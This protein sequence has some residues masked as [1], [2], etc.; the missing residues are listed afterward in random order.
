MLPFLP[1][2]NTRV[3]ASTKGPAPSGSVLWPVASHSSWR[4]WG[5]IPAS[6][7]LHCCSLCL[8]HSPPGYYVAGSLTSWGLCAVYTA[9]RSSWGYLIWQLAPARCSP[10]WPHSQ[11]NFLQNTPVLQSSAFHVCASPA[12]KTQLLLSHSVVSDSFRAHELQHTRLP[13]LS[14][15]L[16]VCSNS[17]PLSRWS[18]PTISPSVAPF[19]SYP[20]QSFP[21]SECFPMSQLFA[22]G[23][24]SIGASASAA[25]LPMNIQS[26]FPLGV[27][28]LISLQSMGLSGV[29]SNTTVEKHQFFGTQPSLRSNSH[30]HTWPPEKP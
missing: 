25:G 1:S 12:P 6:A 16:G 22:P 23:S 5:Y 3:Q 27:T 17:C 19:S 11:L 7:S 10:V 9:V 29:F 26:W 15:S 20:P 24:Q 28:S 18:H 14:Q 8:E 21:A 30:I 4:H 13:C 2:V